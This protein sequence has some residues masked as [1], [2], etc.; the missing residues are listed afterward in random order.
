VTSPLIVDRDGDVETWTM[1]QPETRNAITDDAMIDA[2][3]ANADRVDRDHGV[4][5]VVITGAGKA[6]SS[7]GNV[8]DMAEGKG[9]FGHAAAVQRT[10][11]RDGIQR[12]PRALA[13]V[14][15]PLIAAVNGPAVGAGCDLALMCDLRVASTSA[16]FAESF[17]K[18]G[19]IPG[20]GGAYFL[21]RVIGAAR[22]AEMSLTGDR[23]DAQT[24]LA[25][26][27]VSQVVEPDDL[28][29]AARSLAARVAANPPHAVRMTKQLLRESQGG[30]LD[31]V[32]ELSAAMQAVA[33]QT[34]D[35]HEAV[36][37]FLEKRTPTFTGE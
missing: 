3:V 34:R 6:F 16:F 31:G 24:A 10:A 5:V 29:D 36:S 25:W 33:H 12:I 15:V 14:E 13:A 18:L 19:L 32:L 30:T 11:Y 7:G 28:L 37:A 2:F 1:N 23:V 9:L 20:D 26:G 17:V 8:K 22:A 35:H 4:R 27:M 21:P